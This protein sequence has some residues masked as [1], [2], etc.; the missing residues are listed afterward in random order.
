MTRMT[1]VLLLL[2][3]VFLLFGCATIS[4]EAMSVQVHQQYSTLLDDCE[5]L[6]NISCKS[7]VWGHIT[8]DGAAQQAKY[9][10][11]QAAWDKYQADTLVVTNLD[12][13]FNW[14][15]GQGV[16]LKCQK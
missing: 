9:D 12:V 2:A 16:A 8:W 4:P 7:P 6:G 11:R 1:I 10:L 5:R 14:V 15:Y 13:T 3:S